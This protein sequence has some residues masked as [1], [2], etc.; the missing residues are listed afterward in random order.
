MVD[1]TLHLTA[2]RVGEGLTTASCGARRVYSALIGVRP[3]LVEGLWL[4]DWMARFAAQTSI[5][6][7]RRRCEGS[8]RITGAKT[9]RANRP[10]QLRLRHI[11]LTG[12]SYL[13]HSGVFVQAHS[14]ESCVCENGSV[15]GEGGGDRA[16]CFS[17]DAY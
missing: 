11:E 15:S 6:P 8:L 12:S 10:V 16:S 3:E 2:S 17:T 4:D 14:L 7:F 1:I 5:R 9:S 13:C